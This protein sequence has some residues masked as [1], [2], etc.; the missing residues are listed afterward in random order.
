MNPR[1][2]VLLLV[3]S[4]SSLFAPGSA[5]AEERVVTLDRTCVEIDAATDGLAAADREHAAELMKRVLERADLLVVTTG[6]TETYTLSHERAD[7]EFVIRMRSSAGKRRMR[8]P[9][10]V[11]LSQ[12]YDKMVRSLL[13]AKAFATTERAAVAPEPAPAAAADP[14]RSGAPEVQTAA[15]EPAADPLPTAGTSTSDDLEPIEE[16]PRKR[17]LWYTQLGFQITGGMAATGGYQYHLRSGMILD[18]GVRFRGSE[19]DSRGFNAGVKLLGEKRLNATTSWSAGGGLS[20]GTMERGDAYAGPPYYYEGGGLHADA[21][22]NLQVGKT[23]GV[24]FVSSIELSLPFYRLTNDVGEK[25]YSAAAI[26][27]GGLGW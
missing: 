4:G 23:R 13:V 8:T 11:E 1:A 12:K 6:C 27:T 26:I 3:L 22:L 18:A 17:S 19:T 21:A 5:A 24:Q 16:L 10:L 25:S 14:A 9:A 2:A 15:A 20:L 7:D